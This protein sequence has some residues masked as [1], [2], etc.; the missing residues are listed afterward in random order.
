MKKI[1]F[2]AVIFV[3]IALL[4]F[5]VTRIISKMEHQRL[6]AEKI[7]RFPSFSFLTLSKG[8]YN[9]TDI[10]EGPILVV[11][12]HPECEHCQYEISEILKSNIPA[13]FSK[14]LLVSS[15]HPDSI[16]K[17]LDPFNYSN[18]PS[19]IPLIDAAYNFEEIFGS[20]I[21]PAIYIYDIK[22]NLKKGLHGEVKTE[23][24]LKYLRERE[25]DK[26]N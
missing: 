4:A 21:V 18:Y 17:L 19:V 23:S 24:I 16:R 26:Q 3:M 5:L 8:L 14:V 11:H 22:L 2:S 13:S 10:K 6:D 12:F 9:S 1:I 15:A 20:G 7:S 25:T